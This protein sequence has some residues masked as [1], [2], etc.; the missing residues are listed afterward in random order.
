MRLCRNIK[1]RSGFISDQDIGITCQCHGN[2]DTLAQPPAELERISI[3]AQ[4]WARN[5]HFA[6]QFNSAIAR[7]LLRKVAV[8]AY[9]F[10]DLIADGIMNR[11][12]SHR[13]LED[14]PNAPTTNG[15]HAF[16]IGIESQNISTS[17]TARV[18]DNTTPHNPA[19]PIQNAQDGSC[20]NA[21][22]AAAFPD[23]TEC[24]PC[25]EIEADAFK[26]TH[27]ALLHFEMDREIAYGECN[28]ISHKGQPHHAAHP[29]GN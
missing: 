14:Q 6:Q 28:L 26:G 20:G 1:G 18:K 16:R 19:R 3:N 15:A 17:G 27:H 25:T 11:K 2:A 13:F 7:G 10:D 23:N 12:R 21:F 29:P 8:L 4:F 24:A 9:G 5:P 22:A